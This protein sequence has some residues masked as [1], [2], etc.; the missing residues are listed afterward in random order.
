VKRLY[1]LNQGFL[2]SYPAILILTPLFHF[3]LLS[4]FIE[5]KTYEAHH[6]RLAQQ[7]VNLAPKTAPATQNWPIHRFNGNS[8]VRKSGVYH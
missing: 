5:D 8:P 4:L 7:D 3:H 2:L 6:P 1:I